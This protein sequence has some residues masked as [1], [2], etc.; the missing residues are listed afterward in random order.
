[1]LCLTTKIGRFREY[2][3]PEN[4]ILYYI[5]HR[6]STATQPHPQ[7]RKFSASKE[8]TKIYLKI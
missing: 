7:Y 2:S 5:V 3:H 1:M 8:L 4:S 6:S